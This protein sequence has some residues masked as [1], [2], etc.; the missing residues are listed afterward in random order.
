MDR[1]VILYAKASLDGFLADSQGQT[2]W[3]KGY[4]L[5]QEP[6]P[7]FQSL[8]DRVDTVIMGRITY[9]QMASRF[10][11]DRWPYEG[12]EC[13]VATT[14]FLEDTQQVTFWPGD[15]EELVFLLKQRPG[16]HI[17]LMGGA[18]LIQGF[19]ERELIDSYW[20]SLAPVF[21]G[22]GIRLF[23]GGDYRQDLILD[24]VLEHDGMLTCIYY[25]RA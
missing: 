6:D 14:Q 10:L 9:E 18:R 24:Q 2:D 13:Y 25:N 4:G 11:P 8:M 16:K 17:W 1:E 21:L 22:E 7:G 19:L 23:P 15:L 3:L 5:E 20:I 12:M